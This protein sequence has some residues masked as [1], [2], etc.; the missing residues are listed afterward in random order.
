MA[1]SFLCIFLTWKQTALTSSFLQ[2][3]A[4]C[5]LIDL[6]ASAFAPWMAQV[7]A[8][9]CLGW[10][11]WF[12]FMLHNWHYTDLTLL[13]VFFLFISVLKVIL[14]Q[15]DLAVELLEDLLGIIQVWLSVL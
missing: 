12:Q 6:C 14:I 4:A 3:K 15:I 2:A 11:C 5:I 13:F 7:I 8:K 10:F 9:V 1:L